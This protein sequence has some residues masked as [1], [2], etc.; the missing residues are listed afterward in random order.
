MEN[1]K[2]W[3]EIREVNRGGGKRGGK[4]REK[5]REREGTK[6][7]SVDTLVH[8]FSLLQVLH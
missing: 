6:E 3:S 8:S 4:K 5:E 1:K 2:E 7:E